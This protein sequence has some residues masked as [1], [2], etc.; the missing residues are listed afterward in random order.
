M[1]FGNDSSGRGFGQPIS[2]PTRLGLHPSH[3]PHL[4][5]PS[6]TKDPLQAKNI[7]LSPLLTQISPPSSSLFQGVSRSTPAP[8]GPQGN[9]PRK[10]HFNNYFKYYGPNTWQMP[11]YIINL[12]DKP[13]KII[14]P[15]S[16]DEDTEGQRVR[17]FPKAIQLESSGGRI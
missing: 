7:L 12:L 4:P 14:P 17:C 3:L 13:G 10:L 11:F 15:Q 8:L 1:C 9:R 16:T 6:S 2:L 5:S